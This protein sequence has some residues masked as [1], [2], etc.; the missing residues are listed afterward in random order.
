MNRRGFLKGLLASAAVAPIAVMPFPAMAAVQAPTGAGMIDVL[1]DVRELNRL[2]A[3]VFRQ[4]D[5][6]LAAFGRAAVFVDRTTWPYIFNASADYWLTDARNAE[7]NG[8]R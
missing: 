6:D 1:P 7:A 3:D 2:F 4:W 5:C 8:F